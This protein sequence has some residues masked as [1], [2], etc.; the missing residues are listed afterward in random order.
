MKKPTL[1]IIKSY[2]NTLTN[3]LFICFLHS[4]EEKKWWIRLSLSQMMASEVA[5]NGQQWNLWEFNVRRH[6]RNDATIHMFYILRCQSIGFWDIFIHF[7]DD[8]LIKNMIYDR[9][10]SKMIAHGELHVHT[11]TTQH[12]LI[13]EHFY[14]MQCAL[15]EESLHTVI[16]LWWSFQRVNLY[17]IQKLKLN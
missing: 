2:L 10:W 8:S 13:W 15:V 12:A 11:Q 5:D 9:V 1:N 16:I 17:L 4:E 14:G 7:I 3:D 6:P